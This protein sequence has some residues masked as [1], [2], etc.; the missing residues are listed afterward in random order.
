MDGWEE[1]PRTT[2]AHCRPA[3]RPEAAARVPAGSAATR[4]VLLLVFV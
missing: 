2:A 3:R 1:S 4:V